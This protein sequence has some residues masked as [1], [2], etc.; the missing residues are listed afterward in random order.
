LELGAEFALELIENKS[1][2]GNSDEY[3]RDAF[4]YAD[5][6]THLFL[7]QISSLLDEADF[8]LLQGVFR[9]ALQKGKTLSPEETRAIVE[10]VKQEINS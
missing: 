2:L 4:F 8:Y 9:Y 3:K 6:Y 5:R 7:N 10:E 1:M